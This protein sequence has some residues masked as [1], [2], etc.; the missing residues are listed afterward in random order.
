MWRPVS[1]VTP[2]KKGTCLQEKGGLKRG[3]QRDEHD[4]LQAAG[5]NA[6][7]LSDISSRKYMPVCCTGY[8]YTELYKP[9]ASADRNVFDFLIGSTLY[10]VRNADCKV[11]PNVIV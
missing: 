8:S 2:Q 4:Q 5:G 11:L 9:Q 1:V 6:A 3:C 10:F 7:K